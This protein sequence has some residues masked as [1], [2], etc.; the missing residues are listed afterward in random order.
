MMNYQKRSWAIL[1]KLQKRHDSK[2][3][4][5]DSQKKTALTLVLVVSLIVLLIIL[6]IVCYIPYPGHKL[7]LGSIY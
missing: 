6:L 4:I 3:E 2:F 5:T 7:C 1:E